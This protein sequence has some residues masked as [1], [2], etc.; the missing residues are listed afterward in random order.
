MKHVLFT[1]SLLSA[2][3]CFAADEVTMNPYGGLRLGGDFNLAV[4]YYGPNW[5]SNI[6]MGRDT[7]AAAPGVKTNTV[8]GTFR[9]GAHESFE[10]R[11]ALEKTGDSQWRYTLSFRAKQPVAGT[12][13]LSMDIPVSRGFSPVIDGERH[14]MP[15]EYGNLAIYETPKNKTTR[16]LSFQSDRG[17]ITVTG[18]FSLRIQD[19]RRYKRDCYNV[20]ILVAS[21]EIGKAESAFD[22]R[23]DT[24][25]SVPVDLSRAANMG[26]S[27]E[28]ADDGKG[29]WTDQ[30]PENDLCCIPPGEREFGG[31]GFRI[32]DPAK[33][34]GKSCIVLSALP[35]RRFPESRPIEFA[36]PETHEYLYLLHGAAWTPPFQKEV[37]RI[38]VEYDG[39]E[40]SVFPVLNGIDVGNWWRPAMSYP[41]GLLLWS[42]DNRGGKVG[43]F[44]SGFPLK[45]APVKRIS[46]LPAG[47]VWMIAAA[48]F[49]NLPLERPVEKP[50]LIEAGKEWSPVSFDGGVVKNSPLDFSFLLDA[51]AGKYGRVTGDGQGGLTFEKRPDAKIRFWGTNLCQSALFPSHEEADK[52]AETLARD[53][54]NSVRLHQFERGLWDRKANDTLTF[55]PEQL[56]RFFYLIAKLREKGIYLTTDI[57]ATRPIRPGDGIAE[58]A[59]ADGMERKVL[60]F[61]SPSAMRNWKEYAKRL[62]TTRN[63][64]TGLTLAEDPALYAVN[65]DNESPLLELWNRFPAVA[66]VPEQAYAAWLKEQ[67]IYTPELAKERKAEFRRFLDLRQRETQRE[68]IRAL[69]E[70]GCRFLVTNLNNF[71]STPE[72]QPFRTDL[73]LVD[74]HCYQAHPVYPQ[75]AWSVPTSFS[76]KS[77][78]ADFAASLNGNWMAR[79]F[80]KPLLVT[81]MDFCNPNSYRASGGALAG[82]CGAL[83][84]WSGIYRFSYTHDRKN[85]QRPWSMHGF[86]TIYDPVRTLADRQSA[87]LFLRGDVSPSKEK[88]AFGWNDE[89][90][91]RDGAKEYPEAFRRLGLFGQ[92]GS[93]PQNSAVPVPRTVPGDWENTLPAPFQAALAAQKTGKTVSST[94]ELE[95]DAPGNRLKVVT[96]KSEVLCLEQGALDGNFLKVANVDTFSSISVHS[97]DGKP[98]AESRSILLLHLTNAA[99]T[100]MRFRNADRTLLED[101]GKLPLLVRNGKAEATLAI[102]D[103]S[104]LAVTRLN[105]DGS[106]GKTV[107][108]EA[109]K[110]GVKLPLD[111]SQTMIWHI[112]R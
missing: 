3:G 16:T 82:A 70:L 45:K 35:S 83:Q 32:L 31:I 93:L 53:G 58:C 112:R 111:T 41:N 95:L 99:N 80:G 40:E 68:Q 22:I 20:R 87:L 48:S 78:I 36:R 73:D 66:A 39:A 9:V 42:A 102:P 88:A 37:G 13:A 65:L 56:D 27:D 101:W 17:Q 57:F 108:C 62:L 12:L 84:D 21:G 33:N 110:N 64:Y 43:L 19:N 7:L 15:A 18:E 103:S 29:G 38:R 52:L 72:L 89:F 46:F 76:Q 96:P 26:F 97:L 49:T 107:R 86:D 90:L 54:Y 5:S 61:F 109:V 71:A 8:D 44:G 106:A 69:R 74:L 77:D 75:G 10:V 85:L 24:L 92:V 100:G 81:E 91:K 50:Y 23:L 79:I 59:N 47:G 67:G 2:L 25:A 98:L 105:P 55:D 94:G 14:P 34:G 4:F 28:T 30:G 1:L 104:G 11:G 60:N 51:P 6:R 63:P